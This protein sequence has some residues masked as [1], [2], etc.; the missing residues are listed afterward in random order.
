MRVLLQRVSHAAVD[1]AAERIAEI[2]SG[3]L[4]FVGLAPEDGPAE[5][6]KLADKI[7]GLRIFPSD[8]SPPK[9]KAMNASVVDIGGELLVV[10]QFT[11][12]ADTRRG[13]RPG[14]STAAPPEQALLLYELFV[15]E[16]AK[17]L[18]VKTGR[19][20]ADMQVSLV[21]DGPVTFVLDQ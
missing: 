10:S 18:P 21:N 9:N 16:L 7:L 5:V 19:F 17:T 14:F 1:V 20:G 8:D 4:V 15:S 12:T 3:L 6:S 2:G 13:K 11:L